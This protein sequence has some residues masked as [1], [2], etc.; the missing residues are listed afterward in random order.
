MTTTQ[1]TREHTDQYAADCGELLTRAA[2][3]GTDW[4]NDLRERAM[5]SFTEQ[6]FPTTRH[7]QWKYTNLQPVADTQ[8]ALAREPAELEYDDLRPYLIEGLDAA[9]LVFVDGWFRP[10]LSDLS[11]VGDG[12][13][14]A[15]LSDAM[16][17][18][19]ERVEAKLGQLVDFEDDAF[20]ALNTAFLESGVFVHV[21]AGVAAERPIHVLS[22]S[23]AHQQPIASHP[24]NLIVA[25]PGARA[26]VIEQYIGV[27]EGVYLTNALT[28]LFVADKAHVQHYLL[29]RE[30]P[31]AFNVSTLKLHQAAESDVHSHTALLGGQLVRNNIHPVL[32]GDDIHC[33]INGLYIGNDQQHL[34]NQM[35]VEHRGLRGDS[36]QF[37][38][39]ILNDKSHGVFTGR[40]VVAEG[41]QQTDAKQSNRNLLLSEDARVNARPQLEIYA[42]DVKCTHGATTGQI[43]EEMIFYLRSR[44]I[45]A[46]TARAMMIFAFA[47][48]TFER[49]EVEP[50]ERLLKRELARRLPRAASLADDFDERA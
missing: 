48:E 2:D 5:A 6:G 37:Y 20:S 24:R 7:E 50:I 14:V 43:D 16:A 28:E 46:Q 31:A 39:G 1:T 49:I 23:T 44:G 27:G 10:D 21:A 17:D 32:D 30:S 8:F 26:T 3:A 41:A 9:L 18:H 47:A 25:E 40:I 38:K 15:P 19:R 33:L 29:E 13:I 42:D 35:R 36:R 34:D 12:V 45:D 11:G 22:L 4:A